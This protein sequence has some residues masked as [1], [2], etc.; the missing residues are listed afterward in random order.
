M[1][2]DNR[3]SMIAARSADYY[4]IMRTTLFTFAAIAVVIELGPGGYSAPLTMLVVATAAYG[5]LAGGTALDDITHL[6]D[7]MDE[8]TAKTSYGQSAKARNIPALKMT[9]SI[10]LGLVGLAELYAI[11]M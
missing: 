7:D 3:T 5:I 4:S 2:P 11:L 1:T 6:R 9:S 10:L 8:A